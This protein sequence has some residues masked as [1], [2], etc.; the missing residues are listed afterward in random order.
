MI[1]RL[2]AYYFG[3]VQGIG[4]RYTACDIA[5]RLDITGWVK[6]LRDGRV[7]VMAEGEEGRL[8]TFLSELEGEMGIYVK[9]IDIHWTEPTGEFH[10]FDIRFA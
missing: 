3:T 4:F 5:G 6:N 7:E 1:T 9:D 10:E 2:H 8:K